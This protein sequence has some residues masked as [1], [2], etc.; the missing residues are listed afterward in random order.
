[1]GG[2]K[3]KRGGTSEGTYRTVW[4]MHYGMWNKIF[5]HIHPMVSPFEGASITYGQYGDFGAKYPFPG[6]LQGHFHGGKTFPNDRPGHEIQCWTQFDQCWTHLRQVEPLMANMAM[7]GQ[8][9][10]FFGPPGATQG[11]F[12]GGKKHPADRP[13]YEIQCSNQFDQCATHLR[14]LEPLMANMAI[15]GQ[16]RTFLGPPRPL[17]VVPTM[18]KCGHFVQPS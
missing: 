11:H 5:N 10:S 1:M 14:Q 9:W 15:S 7:P 8:N 4:P 13:G 6:H 16:H 3:W 18:K 2:K 12:H 17:K